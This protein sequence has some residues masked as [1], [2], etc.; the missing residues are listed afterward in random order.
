MLDKIEIKS[1]EEDCLG[2]P[3]TIRVNG[4]EFN[5]L[6]SL[7]FDWKHNHVAVVKIEFSAGEIDIDA[8]AMTA[9]AGMYL[10]KQG[11]APKTDA[12][13]LSPGV[14]YQFSMSEA[15]EIV[16]KLRHAGPVIVRLRVGSWVWQILEALANYEACAPNAL[17]GFPIER[18]ASMAPDLWRA[19]YIDGSVREDRIEKK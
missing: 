9:L 6:Q 16:N 3:L 5:S 19:I 12:R 4:H 15:C 10:A 1:N 13:T 17:M 11:K 7:T 18:D 2:M 8:A 14:S